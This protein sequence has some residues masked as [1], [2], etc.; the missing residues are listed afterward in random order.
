[1]D[2]I[3]IPTWALPIG[4]AAISGAVAWGSMQAVAEATQAEVERV[5]IILEKVTEETDDN[6]QSTALNGQA[7]KSIADSLA[8][9]EQIQAAS[10]QRLAHLVQLL[11]EQN[12]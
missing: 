5:A 4:A 12:K 3:K 2:T 11:L 9:Q 6:T 1:M 7:I 10:D 8:R